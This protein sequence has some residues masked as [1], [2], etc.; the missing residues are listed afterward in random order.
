MT[1]S[2]VNRMFCQALV[3][4]TVLAVGTVEAAEF[5]QVVHGPKAGSI[6][7]L[8]AS[9]LADILGRVFD[10][11][12][13]RS[14]SVVARRAGTILFVGNPDTNPGIARSNFDWP[15]VT[16]QGIVSLSNSE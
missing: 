16:D 3:L 13:V 14:G 5:V 8:A 1:N 4:I 12:E 6:E 11:V 2:I 7:K 10:D 9:E 15:K